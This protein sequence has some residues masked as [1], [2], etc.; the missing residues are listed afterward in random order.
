M[1]YIRLM[2][3]P[4]PGHKRRIRYKGRNPRAYG[5][6][7]KE[8]DPERYADESDKVIARGQTPAGT[9]RPVL[10]AEV[11]AALR[12]APGETGVDATLGYG[13]HGREILLRLR[14][15]G[16]LHAM[17]A[18]PV[19]L[20]RAEARLRGLGFGPEELTVRRMNFADLGGLAAEI[21]P[22]DF[23]LAD[24]GV[25]SM[26]IDSPARGFSHKADGPL[27]LR[28]DPSRGVPAFGLLR[29]MDAKG[30]ERMMTE[31][32]DE[33][34]AAHVAAAVT[35]ALK[36]GEA[37]ETTAALRAAVARALAFVP[38]PSREA[39]VAETCGR[40]FQALRVAVNG[41]YAS[42]DRLLSAI[43]SLLRAGGRAAIISFQ[44]GEDRRVKKAFR[45]GL[46]GCIYREVSPDPARAGSAER[47]SNPRS[48]SAK[49]RWAIRA[50]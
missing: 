40:V 33:P 42:L 14:P 45:E 23:I 22:V 35:A 25:S 41:E 39:A 27:D 32:S 4:I 36:A 50:G 38:A 44:S 31:N 3:E 2:D 17:D 16:R 5:E 26:Q 19:E 43:P 28:M 1:E 34:Y 49:L 7:Y 24:L 9:H 6:K 13:G 12:P 15:G 10:V 18:D 8:L 48:S 21:G 30:F 29:A 20:P 11:L 37:V 46:R 47:E